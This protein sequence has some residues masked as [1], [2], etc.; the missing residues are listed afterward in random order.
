M[1]HGLTHQ[2]SWNVYL[3]GINARA[4]EV[5]LADKDEA[6]YDRRRILDISDEI[7]LYVKPSDDHAPDTIIGLRALA[8]AALEVA[9]SLEAAAAAE[10][11]A[12]AEVGP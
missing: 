12:R 10:A 11:A 3:R 2:D 1:R 5:R 6:D 9:N 8:A 4:V 7:S